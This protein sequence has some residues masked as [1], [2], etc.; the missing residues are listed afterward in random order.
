[1]FA[2]SDDRIKDFALHVITSMPFKDLTSSD[3]S[4]LLQINLENEKYQK[5]FSNEE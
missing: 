3:I 2:K 4:L 5:K 1:M